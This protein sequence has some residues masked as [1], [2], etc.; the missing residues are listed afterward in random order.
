MKHMHLTSNSQQQ[1]L[2][3]VILDGAVKMTQYVVMSAARHVLC[4]R[5]MCPHFTQGQS[6]RTQSTSPLSAMA[7]SQIRA[8]VSTDRNISLQEKRRIK[9]LERL[10][11]Q[12]DNGDVNVDAFGSVESSAP[13]F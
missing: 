3:L 6:T 12:K 9:K 7:L 10:L 11:C 8:P 4:P 5:V 1:P 13:V 2:G